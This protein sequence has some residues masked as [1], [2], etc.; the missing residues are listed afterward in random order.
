MDYKAYP[1][2]IENYEPMFKLVMPTLLSYGLTEDSMFLDIGCGSLRIGR[3]LI[4]F[5]RPQHYFGLEPERLMVREALDKEVIAR[6]GRKLFRYKKPTFRFNSKFNLST[7]DVTFDIA[8]ALHVFVHCHTDL[9]RQCLDSVKGK[10]KHDGKFILN[11]N[12]GDEYYVKEQPHKQYKYAGSSWVIYPEEMFLE[13]V[14]EHGFKAE[15]S[16]FGKIWCLTHQ[17]AV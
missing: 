17:E 13:I 14:S 1:G 7:L 16:N 12:T 11:V 15:Y 6:Y 4:M 8:M 5:L 2:K 10:L 9:L 3:Y